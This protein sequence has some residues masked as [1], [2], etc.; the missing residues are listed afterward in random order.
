MENTGSFPKYL[1]CKIQTDGEK[2]KAQEREFDMILNQTWF[3]YYFSQNSLH[4]PSES[5]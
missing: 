4:F 1:L 5:T 3:C 2:K